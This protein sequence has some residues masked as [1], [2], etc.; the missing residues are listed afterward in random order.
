MSDELPE[1]VRTSGMRVTDD[2][3]ALGNA[4]VTLKDGTTVVAENY[5]A[6]TYGGNE[7]TEGSI[8]F[9]YTYPVDPDDVQSIAFGG[10]DIDI[11]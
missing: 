8:E 5:S 2:M 9:R 7:A 10:F 3:H 11:G 4:V 1:G 6:R